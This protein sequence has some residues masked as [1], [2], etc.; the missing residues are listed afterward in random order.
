M[1]VEMTRS[2]F[3]EKELPAMLWGEA[4]R[5][6]VYVLNR[7]PTQALS[8][9]TP[10]EAWSGN[11]P[12][13][14]H[15]R[16]FGCLAHMKIPNV[17]TKKLDDRSMQ[18]INLGSEPGTKAYRLFDP[19]RKRIFVSRDVVFEEAKGW[20][21]LHQDGDDTSELGSFSVP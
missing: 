10:Y 19:I 13:L 15:L 2:Y 20:P 11:K 18:V 17:Y 1:V 3:K 16:V 8:N 7:L 14:G 12:N 5:Q 6:S 21:W 9:Q 4:V